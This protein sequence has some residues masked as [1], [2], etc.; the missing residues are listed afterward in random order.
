M[1]GSSHVMRRLYSVIWISILD[2]DSGYGTPKSSS[3][4]VM[5]RE[6]GPGLS[7]CPV[8]LPCNLS[9]RV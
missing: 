1:S 7:V 8:C 9:V 4:V 6:C 3:L 5:G 2:P